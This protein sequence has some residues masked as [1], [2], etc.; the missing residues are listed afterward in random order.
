MPT[1]HAPSPLDDEP[2]PEAHRD[3]DGRPLA[4]TTISFDDLAERRPIPKERLLRIV[5][6]DLVRA[7]DVQ[8][9]AGNT[10]HAGG[11]SPIDL[12]A[13]VDV[14]SVRSVAAWRSVRLRTPLP[15][16]EELL[17][18]QTP[19]DTETLRNLPNLKRLHSGRHHS[20]THRYLGTTGLADDLEKLSVAR[21]S[22]AHG[23]EKKLPANA[24]PR[25]SELARFTKLRHLDLRD[26]WPGDSIAPAAA[27]T[28]LEWL[29]SD[30]AGG[31]TKLGRL[32]RLETVA[33]IKARVANLRAFAR[34]T[35]VRRVSLGNAGIKS[36]DGLQA[37]REL[38]HLHCF[39]LRVDDLSPLAGLPRLREITFTGLENA[40]DLTPLGTLPALARLHIAQAGIDYRS[41]VH[42]HSIVPLANAQALEELTMHYT[43]ID[44]GDASPLAALPK[45]RRVTLYGELGHTVEALRAARPDVAVAW[46]A[47]LNAP[48]EKVGVVYV[49]PPVDGNAR[50]WISE[51]LTKLL[52]TSTNA[53]AERRLVHTLRSENPELLARL[54]FDTE[55][56]AVYALAPSRA[57][58]IELAS[59]IGRLAASRH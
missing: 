48:G 3:A 35:R 50:W 52:S 17:S 39:L 55:A 54:E 19:P 12:D 25:F 46:S 33:A 57:D 32:E 44:D 8:V 47:P 42:V 7:G 59:F 45:L 36:L 5:P 49:R 10:I 37:F 18:L 15:H 30:A 56:S 27:L 38:E 23:W 26:C 29:S 51:D 41:I 31:W 40:H 1:S 13:L 16:V 2:V 28:N 20:P 6:L 22:L 9:R 34:W 53:D 4:P 58:I 24:S 11:Q 43:I 21:H 14:P